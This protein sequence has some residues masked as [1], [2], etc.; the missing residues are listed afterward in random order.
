ML[1]NLF[2]PLRAHGYL[3]MKK[4]KIIKLFKRNKKRVVQNN[5]KKYANPVFDDWKKSA[6]DEFLKKEVSAEVAKSGIFILVVLCIIVFSSF[7][8]GSFRSKTE[9]RINAV[10][11]DAN[12]VLNEY[13]NVIK[14]METYEKYASMKLKVPI[15]VQSAVILSSSRTGFFFDSISFE[16]TKEIGNLKEPFV[17]ETGKG[18]DETVVLGIWKF[19]GL[20]MKEADNRWIMSLKDTIEG[21]FSLFGVKSYTSASLRGKD[22]EATV[23]I[24]E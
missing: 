23:V 14:D 17:V 9:A 8:L 3:K 10:I 5:K 13:G 21:T 22:V 15:Y 6:L 1:K 18:I 20:V 7:V 24:Y 19:K 11:A 2:L 4:S 16:K 12:K